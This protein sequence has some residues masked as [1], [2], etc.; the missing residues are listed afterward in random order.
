M[1][2]SL[3]EKLFVALRG[4]KRSKPMMCG[5]VAVAAL[6]ISGCA[7]I[8]NLAPDPAQFRLLPDRN[9]L[10]PTDMN[11]YTT[12]VSAGG[13]PAPTELTDAQ[14]QCA[15]GPG[16]GGRG[17]A[18]IALQMTE[19]Q[20]VR[21]LGPPQSADVSGGPIESRASVLTYASG[22][23]PGIYRFSAGRLVSMELGAELPPPPAPPKKKTAKKPKPQGA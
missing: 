20:V 3:R 12:G 14:G 19:C 5:V 13:P 18:G 11:A 10:L 16:A 23:R 9:A 8:E 22:D 7:S 15:G 21:T 1:M 2:L 4:R 6:A 17:A